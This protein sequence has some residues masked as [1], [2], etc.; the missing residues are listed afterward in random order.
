MPQANIIQ[1][2]FT[3]GEVSPLMYGRIDVN[4]YFNGARQLVNFIVRPQGGAWRR[5]GSKFVNAT[6]DSSK[7]SIV[8]EFIFSNVQAY[9][10][11]FGHQ[12]VRIYKDHGIVESTPGNPVEVATPYGENDLEQLYFSQSADVLYIC[13]PNYQTRK[14]S[15]TSHTAWTLTAYAPKNGPYLDLG[16]ETTTLFVTAEVDY[17]TMKFTGDVFTTGSPSPDIGKFIEFQDGQLWRLAKVLAVTSTTEATVDIIDDLIIDYSTAVQVKNNASEE[18]FD[19]DATGVFKAS[20]IGKYCRSTK[21]DPVWKLMDSYESNTRM[22]YLPAAAHPVLISYDITTKIPTIVGRTVATVIK[23]TAN[24]FASTDVGRWLRLRFGNI[25][26]DYKITIF[27]SATQVTGES[28]MTIP[29]DEVKSGTSPYQGGRSDAWR[30]GAWSSTT[31]W[32]TIVTFHEQRLVFSR[33]STQPQT[34]WFSKSGDYE[35]FAPTDRNGA[36][37]ADSGIT[38]T[39]ASNQ[40][41]PIV[42]METGP[43]MLVG[44]IGSE[45]QCKA[46]S[47]NEAISPTNIDFKEQSRFGAIFNR[48]HRVGAATLFIQRGGKKVREMV[49]DFSIDAFV[50]K[51]LT[52]ISEHILRQ[53]TG[54]KSSAFQQETA[55]IMWIRL[56]NGELAGMT[57]ERDQEVVAWHRHQLGGSGIV[58]SVAVVP[59]ADGTFDNAYLVVRRTINGQTKRYIE[60]ITP[61]FTMDG[62]VVQSDMFFVDCGLSYSGAPATTFTGLS[63][64]EGC[65]VQVLA[66]GGYVGTKVVASGQVTLDA[67]ASK[68]HIGLGFVSTIQTLDPE[69]GS[70]HGTS[71]GK[72]KRIHTL[73]VRVKDT[74]PFYHGVAVADSVKCEEFSAIT[75]GDIHISLQQPYS[76]SGSY[77]IYQK[78]PVALNVLALIPQ[79]VTNQ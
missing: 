48:P 5:G 65:T 21:P 34:V 55:G 31:G 75:T 76:D 22:K 30:L 41:N 70:V 28:E 43:V 74:L 4:K 2:N 52:I 66:D 14:L 72:I 24:L 53:A 59:E 25:W 50:S 38:Y 10:L 57:Y 67:A 9:I 47:I 16:D 3:S 26:V 29:R 46:T 39:I 56:G 78:D 60:R 6:K 73:S 18:R 40:A 12:Y 15:R 63:H 19:A 77:T 42:W 11:E 27:T 17:A 58:E 35:D 20:D 37:L 64:L 8:R 69:G 32:P 51:D 1:T 44:T 7:K 13:H 62:G 36:V 54:G 23:S 49:Y 33:T 68:V 79:L 45:F 61:E 71:Q